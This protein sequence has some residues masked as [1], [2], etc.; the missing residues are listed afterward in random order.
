LKQLH[1][2]IQ[3]AMNS[4][5]PRQIEQQ[6]EKIGTLKASILAAK[7]T[8]DH[9]KQ[10]E[11]HSILSRHQI[12]VNPSEI[13]RPE[14]SDEVR[15]LRS[16]LGQ[17][18]AL[19]RDLKKRH[20]RLA[21]DMTAEFEE[22]RRA[23]PVIALSDSDE[24]FIEPIVQ[25]LIVAVGLFVQC[26]TEGDVLGLFSEFGEIRGIKILLQRGSRPQ[27][28]FV[29]I[30][31]ASQADAEAAIKQANGMIVDN[32]PLNVK[33]ATNQLPS[34]VPTTI[35]RKRV[36]FVESP[37]PPS[38][39]ALKSRSFSSG[40][41]RAVM[42]LRGDEIEAEPLPFEKAFLD[43][44]PRRESS[45]QETILFEFG[46]STPVKQELPVEFPRIARDSLGLCIS[47]IVGCSLEND[48]SKRTAHA[49]E[50]RANLVISPPQ[51][52]IPICPN[53]KE[54]AVQSSDKFVSMALDA[55]ARAAETSSS[56][57]L[58]GSDESPVSEPT[59]QLLKRTPTAD[60]IQQT[61]MLPAKVAN[62]SEPDSSSHVTE[63]TQESTFEQSP[64][65]ADEDLQLSSEP[66]AVPVPVGE[67]ISIVVEPDLSETVVPD[68]HS[69][70]GV[71]VN[72]E[73]IPAEEE[74]QS[75]ATKSFR[76]EAS[77][78]ADQNESES[79]AVE[80]TERSENDASVDS[81]SQTAP[82]ATQ[83]AN[84]FPQAVESAATP[85][86][87]VQSQPSSPTVI[88]KEKEIEMAP[89]DSDSSDEQ[90]LVSAV[91]LPPIFAGSPERETFPPIKT[92]HSQKDPDEDGSLRFSS[93]SPKENERNGHTSSDGS[94]FSGS[95]DTDSK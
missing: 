20:Q 93:D 45:Q 57:N 90:P 54:E 95:D 60:A 2:R 37:L 52:P 46:S 31:F 14:S 30:A 24:S 48:E 3:I 76:F 21:E 55:Q 33:W 75:E 56:H 68:V 62:E 8:H 64:D 26:P 23:K 25:N 27:K 88:E 53:E 4:R 43:T 16:V 22:A 80:V 1:H 85:V 50:S 67:F 94:W 83:R 12:R 65:C 66:S 9:L 34:S 11:R 73:S 40:L 72:A 6:R 61:P 74:E 70:D 92:F 38:K 91:R 69:I 39:S 36:A 28:Y 17:Q 59:V 13:T 89:H 7:E 84:G 41:D 5:N 35:K 81:S 10:E 19:F 77:G 78:V 71:F 29:K 63:Q 32:V 82:N 18:N 58:F 44:V 51:S 47:A 42:H 86:K 87:H 49:R 79:R 15:H